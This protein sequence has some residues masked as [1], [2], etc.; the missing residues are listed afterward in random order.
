MND[1]RHSDLLIAARA[2]LDLTRPNGV[3]GDEWLA[4]VPYW[5]ELDNALRMLD[6]AAD[7]CAPPAAP[8]PFPTT[9][10]QECNRADIAIDPSEIGL[11]LAAMPGVRL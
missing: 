5:P 8:E 2:V 3:I 1:P 11:S 9:C 10:H 4:R 6:A 7:R